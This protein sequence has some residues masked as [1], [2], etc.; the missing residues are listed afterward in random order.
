MG[1]KLSVWCMIG[2]KRAAWGVTRH[3]SLMC[4]LLFSQRWTHDFPLKFPWWL[5]SFETRSRDI[6]NRWLLHHLLALFS[7][8]LTSDFFRSNDNR[9]LVNVVTVNILF[10]FSVMCDSLK[11]CDRYPPPPIPPA[12]KSIS[13]T[14]LLL[15]VGSMQWQS[16]G[17]IGYSS[18]HNGPIVAILDHLFCP[19]RKFFFVWP[20]PL[21]T[22]LV[23]SRWLIITGLTLRFRDQ[24]FPTAT[25]SVAPG[26]LYDGKWK[27]NI[28]KR[29]PLPFDSPPLVSGLEGLNVGWLDAKWALTLEAK[30]DSI[31]LHIRQWWMD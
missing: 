25:M 8:S 31:I 16:C 29:N 10:Y 18:G 13:Y 12:G 19:A 17:L 5:I 6:K 2:P 30:R 4:D 27:R 1:P 9:L 20:Y 28:T 3:G 21:L 26:Y 7:P 23:H 15:L 11:N 24:G 22:K 14:L